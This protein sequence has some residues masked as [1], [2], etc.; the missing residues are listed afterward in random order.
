MISRSQ[1]YKYVEE[2]F[3]TKPDYPWSKFPGYA[4]FRH[5]G[6]DKWFGLLMNVQREKLKLEGEGEVEVLNIKSDAEKV[7]SL[8]QMNGILPA[9]HMN[10]EHWVSVLLDGSVSSADIKSLI[11]ESFLLTK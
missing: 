1:I 3:Q 7:G 10:K 9:Y 5:D 11:D 8:R 4:V 2:K 6:N